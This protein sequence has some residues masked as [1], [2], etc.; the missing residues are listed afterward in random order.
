MDRRCESN[1]VVFLQWWQRHSSLGVLT[2]YQAPANDPLRGHRG[3]ALNANKP[4]DAD[5]P[6]QYGLSTP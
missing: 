6:T 3:L 1:R 2:P 5:R 4:L